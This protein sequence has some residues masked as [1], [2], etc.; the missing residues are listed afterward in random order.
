MS[1][2]ANIYIHHDNIVHNINHLKSLAPNSKLLAMVK[3]NA[4]GHGI[5]NVVAAMRGAD[6]FGVACMSEGV[7]LA[8]RLPDDDHRPI[9]LMQGAFSLDEWKMAIA[10]NF[11][12]VVHC[13]EQ[14]NFALNLLP[15]DG[16]HTHTLW[17]KYN[18]GMYRLGFSDDDILP[19]AKRLL[20]KGYRLIL[21]SHFACADDK[22]N[23][24]NAVQIQKFNFVFQQLKDEYGD[25]VQGSLCNSAGI[26]NFDEVHYDWVRSGIALYGGTPVADRTASELGLRPAMSLSA[27][28]MAIQPLKKGEFLGYGA[29]WQ[30]D[31]DKRIG[32]VSLGYGDGYPR[33]VQGA[34][35]L[36]NNEFCPIVGRVAMDMIAVDL[37]ALSQIVQVGEPVLFW[38]EQNGQAISIDEVAKS[39]GTIGYELMCRLTTRA[40]RVVVE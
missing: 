27:K 9:V 37:T 13:D 26:V 35:V 40:D 5:D 14:A 39:A 30:A 31:D 8:K 38:G 25:R 7:A 4:Y 32:I 3:A 28:I 36:I 2:T 33:V 16:T 15:K 12:C 23:P 34:K 1:R 6:G 17:L 11:A 29:T 20:E 18:T 21:T 22:E 19:V 10:Q 24:M